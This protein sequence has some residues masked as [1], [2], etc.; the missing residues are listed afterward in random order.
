MHIRELAQI[1][2]DDS[3]R[4]FAVWWLRH[5]PFRPPVDAVTHVGGFSGVTLYR[6]GQFQVQFFIAKPNASAPKHSHPNID[7]VEYGIAGAGQD[8]FKSE[9]NVHIGGLFMI[10]PCETHTAQAGPGGGAFLSFQKWLNGVE[11]SS[12]E[13]DW[14]G[15]PIDEMHAKEIA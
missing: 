15:E 1:S 12:V 8:T 11:P 14:S 4:S 5:K 3:V 9:R 13:L 7:S 10:A 6:Q 2:P